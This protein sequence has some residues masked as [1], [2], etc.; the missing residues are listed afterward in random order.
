MNFL[1]V[2]FLFLLVILSYFPSIDVDG[3]ARKVAFSALVGVG[4]G[5]VTGAN[6]ILD[7]IA[8]VFHDISSMTG[9]FIHVV[10]LRWVYRFSILLTTELIIDRDLSK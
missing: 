5:G 1:G 9:V 4:A 8:L 2:I 10:S 7:F 3:A 6:I